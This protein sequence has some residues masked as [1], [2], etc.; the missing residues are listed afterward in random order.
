MTDKGKEEEY[1]ETQREY[2]VSI[3]ERPWGQYVVL[4]NEVDIKVKKIIV[5]PGN[6]L[7]LQKHKLREEHWFVSKGEATVFLNDK[8]IILKVGESIDVK[9]GDIHR[10]GN[11]GQELLVFVEVQTGDHFGEDD[12]ECLEDDYDREAAK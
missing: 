6:R 11:D 2:L 1:L 7:S 4:A 9:R 8:K 5:N 10:I 3:G 12:I